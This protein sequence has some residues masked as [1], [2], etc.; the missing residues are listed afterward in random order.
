[1]RNDNR[2]VKKIRVKGEKFWKQFPELAQYIKVNWGKVSYKEI[3]NKID[4]EAQKVSK[5]LRKLNPKGN[6]LLKEYV[7][8]LVFYTVD[9][10]CRVCGNSTNWQ[11]DSSTYGEY[12]SRDCVYSDKDEINRRKEKTYYKNYGVSNYF[13]TEESKNKIKNYWQIEEGVNNPAQSEKVKQKIRNTNRKR[14]NVD[15]PLQS[16]QI[17]RK[18]RIRNRKKYGVDHPAKTSKVKDKIKNSYIEKYGVDH[19]MKN[20][21]FKEKVKDSVRNN[22][23][24][25]N[26]SKIKEVKDKKERKNHENYSVDC[27]FQSDKIKNE[28]KETLINKYGVTNIMYLD[29]TKDKMKRTFTKRYGVEH[30]MKNE[31][32][33]K[34]VQDSQKNSDPY[35]S[36]KVTIAGKTIKVQGYEAPALIELEKLGKIKKITTM[37]KNTPNIRYNDKNNKTRYYYPDAYIKTYNNNYILLEVKSTYTLYKNME[38]NKKKFEAAKEHCKGKNITFILA[39]VLNSKQYNGKDFVLFITNPNDLDSIS[40]TISEISR[41]DRI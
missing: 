16:E 33:I 14:Y 36:K 3:Q 24:V 30:P 37:R 28:I 4:I 12:C 10:K 41:I 23:G 18:S 34:K 29:A 25:E 9:P 13:K 22:H 2:I 26:V 1:M 15:Y 11:K 40:K 35:K 19:P 38:L 17:K 32:I 21:E 7:Y 31:S 8:N 39:I 27:L 20:N 6:R 5:W